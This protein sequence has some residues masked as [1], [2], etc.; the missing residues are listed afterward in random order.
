[1][2]GQEQKNMLRGPNTVDIENVWENLEKAGIETYAL[3]A[4]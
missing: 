2:E 4:K 3:Q 1:M